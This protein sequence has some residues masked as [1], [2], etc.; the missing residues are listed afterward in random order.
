MI[1]IDIP[2]IDPIQHEPKVFFGMTS[3]QILCLLP[4]V[5]VGG[6]LFAFTVST[7]MSVAIV[8]LMIGVAP[9]V[10]MGWW[11]PYNMKCE[12]YLKLLYFNTFVSSPKRIYKTDSEEDPKVASMRERKAEEQLAKETQLNE[13][14]SRN[15]KNV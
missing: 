15:A 4:G 12:Q 11:K 14:K 9:S 2:S 7:D 1:E 13:K 5:A 10:A 8:L 3:R 6:L